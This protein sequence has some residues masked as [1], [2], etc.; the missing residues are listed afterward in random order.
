MRKLMD[1][2]QGLQ[3]KERPLEDQITQVYT[4]KDEEEAPSGHVPLPGTDCEVVAYPVNE[5]DLMV[6]L[7]KRGV[8]VYRCIL[9]GALRTDLDVMKANLHMTEQRIVLGEPSASMQEVVRQMLEKK[10]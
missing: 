2:L 5:S 10:L 6:L 1:R 9:A 8:C 7:N 3:P 4:E